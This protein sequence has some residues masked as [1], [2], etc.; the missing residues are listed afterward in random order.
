MTQP[1]TI[2]HHLDLNLGQAALSTTQKVHFIQARE[3]G[4]KLEPHFSS[5]ELPRYVQVGSISNIS[6]TRVN[7]E[8]ASKKKPIGVF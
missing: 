2:S 3:M 1:P 8:G 7:N 6:D 4:I 5:D